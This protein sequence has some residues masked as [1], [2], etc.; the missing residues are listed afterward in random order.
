MRLR[1]TTNPRP[2]ISLVLLIDGSERGFDRALSSVLHQG[3]IGWE[4]VIVYRGSDRDGAC[5]QT[6]K[7]M[8]GSAIKIVWVDPEEGIGAARNLAVRQTSGRVLAYLDGDDEF[9]QGVVEKFCSFVAHD[10]LA[11]LARDNIYYHTDGHISHH[12][13]DPV[14]SRHTL[15]MSSSPLS[16]GLI[17]TRELWNIVGGFDEN[18]PDGELWDFVRKSA[19]I[20]ANLLFLPHRCGVCHIDQARRAKMATSILGHRQRSRLEA[21][22]TAGFP[23]YQGTP[24]VKKKL[25]APTVIYASPELFIDPYNRPAEIA[26]NS[27]RL[28][29]NQ[30]FIVGAICTSKCEPRG[31][32]TLTQH[33]T[34]LTIPH[35]L[36]TF[37]S[38]EPTS[39][40]VSVGFGSIDVEVF[41]KRSPRTSWYESHEIYNF[42][43]WYDLYLDRMRPDVAL[44][45]TKNSP[46]DPI[47]EIIVRLARRRDIPVALLLVESSP[48]ASI[49]QDID[50]CVAVSEHQQKRL[51][52]DFRIACEVLPP[53]VELPS[54]SS[55][56][57]AQFLILIPDTSHLGGG[58]IAARIVELFMRIRPEVGFIAFDPSGNGNWIHAANY[59]GI[60]LAHCSNLEVVANT[61]DM[62]KCYQRVSLLLCP[63]KHDDVSPYTA[64][65]AM[66]RAI[67]VL[68][69]DRGGFPEILRGAGVIVELSLEY[70]EKL[71]L[72]PPAESIEPWTQALLELVDDKEQ[73]GRLS[74]ACL[75]VANRSNPITLSDVYVR[76]FS[77]LRP[78]PV[79]PVIRT[80]TASIPHPIHGEGKT[81]DDQLDE[82]PHQIGSYKINRRVGRGGMGVVF[83]AQGRDGEVVALKMIS[84]EGLRS[85]AVLNQF[86][87]EA[88]IARGLFH[89]N[90]VN[91]REIGEH[92]GQPFYTMQLIDGSPF[93]KVLEVIR[94]FHRL[95]L[96]ERR[97]PKPGH[98]MLSDPVVLAEQFF[99]ANSRIDSSFNVRPYVAKVLRFGI[100][101]S[102]ALEYI[103]TRGITHRDLA[104]SNL[105][106][107]VQG[108][109]LISDFGLAS[110]DEDQ[111]DDWVVTA[112]QL[113]YLAPERYQGI[114]DA[115]SD[116]YSLGLI[117]Y[118][119]IMLDA[120]N[121]GFPARLESIILKSLAVDPND[122]YHSASEFAAELASYRSD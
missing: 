77:S 113:D 114:C 95:S 121:Y 5:A 18:L 27:L 99:L 65:N 1:F 111:A 78:C 75:E 115:R 34:N 69:S 35:Q 83:E 38:I 109:V 9:Y 98:S 122:R 23:L 88:R 10:D 89:P 13:W 31:D 117:L 70:N 17:H 54:E 63:W 85:R 3:L 53:I 12:S 14:P 45:H 50:S 20:G 21:R 86:L 2:D 62:N 76:Y 59:A 24:L 66:C 97:L 41:E 32:F 87:R 46:T 52:K 16:I 110:Q 100:Q 79:P 120:L 60:N 29:K 116:I 104:P 4:L 42:S 39:S 102:E 11:I 93:H 26:G 68:A 101:L 6:L 7:R 51:W 58:L 82:T 91:T 61:I 22:V 80:A 112:G 90:I 57:K 40:I 81:R 107:S 19:R 96:F 36:D 72:A 8:V 71:D 55:V 37:G 48:D 73:Y 43:V 33:L 64:V 44:V 49:L 105:M 25:S 30:G 47:Y 118:Q 67:P 106:I 84:R 108:G 28:L 74:K 92:E 56:E 94:E 103:H 119:L 15:F